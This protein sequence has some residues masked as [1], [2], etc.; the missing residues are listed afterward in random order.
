MSTGV[1]VAP[2]GIVFAAKMNL[3]QETDLW[4]KIVDEVVTGSAVTS[5]DITGLDLD[6]AK[7]YM[8]V[9][10]TQNPTGSGA[11][12]RLYFNGDTTATNYWRQFVEASAAVVTGTRGNDP[13]I[14]Y[15]SAGVETL[16][17]GFL[18]RETG[19]PKYISMG[20]RDEQST[21]MIFNGAMD[22]VTENNVTRITFT[23]LVANTIGIGSR[24][25]I[26]RVIG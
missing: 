10:R 15:S 1:P 14:G 2:G 17:I 9:F 6:A 8:I 7:C 13:T 20:T 11:Y 21:L 5:I 18:A 16:L 19:K 25:M 4:E 3:K 24:V 23:N 26:F 22:W 12:M